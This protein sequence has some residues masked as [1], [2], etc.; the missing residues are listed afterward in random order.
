MKNTL[1]SVVTSAYN[2]QDFIRRSVE[3]VINQSYD[4]YEYII[5]DNGSTDETLTIIKKYEEE[6]PKIIR[7]LHLDQN[8]GISGG[9][10]YGIENAKGDYVCFLDADD[11]WE[12]GK[13]ASVDKAIGDHSECNIFCHWE[14]HLRENVKTIAE[15]RKVDIANPFC[16]LL[17][18]GNCLSTSAMSIKKDLLIK[19]GGFDKNLVSGEE[20]F[21]LWLRLT[22]LGGKI[23]MIDEPL[24]YWVIRNDSVSAKFLPHTESVVEVLNKYFGLLCKEMCG[25]KCILKKWKSTVAGTYCSCGRRLSM[26][27]DRKNAFVMYKKAIAT[28][29][30]YLKSYAGILLNIIHL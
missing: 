25:D 30:S 17:V 10:N 28:C 21:D 8:Q 16:D 19:T 22:R 24:G 12:E 26:R 3:S 29:P 11:F 27:G 20:D 6:F 1:F 7:V 13:L 14:Y 4:N 18:N 2:A 5:V 15:Y 23:Y 9:R